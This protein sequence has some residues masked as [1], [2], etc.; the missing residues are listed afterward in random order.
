MDEYMQ[1][2]T[3]KKSIV[4]SKILAALIRSDENTESISAWRG[5]NLHSKSY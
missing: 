2:Q 4:E 5:H 3:T 1:K